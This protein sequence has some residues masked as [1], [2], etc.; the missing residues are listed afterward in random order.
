[1]RARRNL[2]ACTVLLVV[3]IDR[4]GASTHAIEPRSGE[5][6]ILPQQPHGLRLWVLSGEPRTYFCAGGM[7]ISRRSQKNRHNCRN[8]S[9][10]N[11]NVSARVS[12][13]DYHSVLPI[14]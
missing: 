2:R 1:M 14:V 11:L 10:E 9:T 4:V 7:R 3:R 12:R 8:F 5:P 13:T 6:K